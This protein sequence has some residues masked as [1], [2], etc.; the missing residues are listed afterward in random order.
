MIGE[1]GPRTICIGKRRLI[2]IL[3]VMMK[4][5][6]VPAMMR[7]V[8]NLMLFDGFSLKM[9]K[10][11]SSSIGTQLKLETSSSKSSSESSLNEAELES[12]DDFHPE[13]FGLM[14]NPGV[15]R[16]DSLDYPLT[17]IEG[18][19]DEDNEDT[20]TYRLGH[21]TERYSLSKSLDNIKNIYGDQ[22]QQRLHNCGCQLCTHISR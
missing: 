14:D 16:F 2:N 13:L 7:I 6:V 12:E 19:D 9:L 11:I 1:V 10:N 20:A 17:V 3:L 8:R 5:P 15:V 4:N 21:D 18:H 22:R